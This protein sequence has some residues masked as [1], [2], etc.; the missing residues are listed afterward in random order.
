MRWFDL[1]FPAAMIIYPLVFLLLVPRSPQ[2]TPRARS[3]V[4]MLAMA[5]AVALAGHLALWWFQVPL[6]RFAFLLTF[7]L[8]FGLAVPAMLAR[9]P[10]WARS[11][12]AD[13]GIRRASLQPRS[14]APMAP[15]WLWALSGCIAAAALAGVALRPFGEPMDEAMRSAW[16]LALVIEVCLLSLTFS[17]LP[18][19]IQMVRTEA[20][21]LDARASAEVTQAYAALRRMKACAF[22]WLLGVGMNLLLGVATNAIAWLPPGSPALAMT[23][24]IGGAAGGTA[25]GFAGAAVG[26]LST[27]RRARITQLLRTLDAR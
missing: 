3:L 5:T 26:V 4:R 24:A 9:R 1:L 27:V 10:D 25:L 20:E 19:V 14:Q 17:L 8:F 18:F 7:P 22:L 11:H 23:I 13:S 2:A 16:I 15:R 6:A 12:P 21:P